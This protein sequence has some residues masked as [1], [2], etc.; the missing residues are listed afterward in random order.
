MK[1]LS[2]LIMLILLCVIVGCSENP[3]SP[4]YEGNVSDAEEYLRDYIE[5]QI[6]L[7]DTITFSEPQT[8]HYDY[9][10][11]TEYYIRQEYITTQPN[12]L[13][14]K[15][16]FDAYVRYSIADKRYFCRRLL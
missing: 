10:W 5:N 2:F 11:G 4:R 7:S 13:S 1:T 12:G 6:D 15:D 14:S 8:N 9:D 3:V 16:T